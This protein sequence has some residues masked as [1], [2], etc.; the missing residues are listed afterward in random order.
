MY[1]ALRASAVRCTSKHA[2]RRRRASSSGR[3]AARAARPGHRASPRRSPRSERRRRR[4]RRRP[5][6]ADPLTPLH[7]DAARSEAQPSE[8][9]ASSAAAR[10]ASRRRRRAPRR[11]RSPA[12]RPR[13]RARR[14]ARGARAASSS[15]ESPSRSISTSSSASGGSQRARKPAF[16][17]VH[18][19]AGTR[20]APASSRTRTSTARRW[21]SPRRCATWAPTATT[22]RWWRAGADRSS[23]IR[24]SI[25]RTPFGG[26]PGGSF[27]GVFVPG[28]VR[29]PM[30]RFRP[31]RPLHVRRRSPEARNSSPCSKDRYIIS[32]RRQQHDEIGFQQH[33][34]Q[35]RR[36]PRPPT[37]YDRHGT[38]R[39]NA[40]DG[41]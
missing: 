41:W 7:S 23:S 27:S 11:R 9:R 22:A 25:S 3:R 13:R 38:I 6:R 8:L 21:S 24:R 18:L 17:N 37:L 19:A 1:A 14:P 40:E 34:R 35:R 4:K 10:S 16:V 29:S 32:G 33:S 28:C 20:R 31:P 12:G 5:T 2:R 39:R 30:S 15:G 36:A 26:R